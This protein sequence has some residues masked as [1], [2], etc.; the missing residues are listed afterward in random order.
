MILFL[1]LLIAHFLGDFVLQP[2]T[3]ESDIEQHKAKSIKLYLHILM[4]IILMVILTLD[5]NLRAVNLM[6]GGTEYILKGT[7]LS[8]GMAILM[9]ILYLKL[10]KGLEELKMQN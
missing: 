6:I 7:L 2:K 1:I 3:W 4:H 10:T 8:F 9:G 5:I